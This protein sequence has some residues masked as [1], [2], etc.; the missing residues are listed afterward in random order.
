VSL[1]GTPS[2]TLFTAKSPRPLK[3]LLG[4]LS[5]FCGNLLTSILM[6]KLPNEICLIIKREMADGEWMIGRLM[7]IVD[8]CPR[9]FSWIS[10]THEKTYKQD[11]VAS[12]S[13]TDHCVYGHQ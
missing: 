1:S 6:G 4:I 9:A 7:E 10:S 5:D 3:A 13:G 2:V 8:R 11:F 12:T